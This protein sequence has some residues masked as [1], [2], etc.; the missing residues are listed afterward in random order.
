MSDEAKL[1]EMLEQLEKRKADLMCQHQAAMAALT[2]EIEHA[3]AALY[4]LVRKQ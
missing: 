3:K 4:D 1:K 2:R